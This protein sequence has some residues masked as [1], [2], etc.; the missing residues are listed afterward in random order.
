MLLRLLKW[1]QSWLR[2]RLWRSQSLSRKLFPQSL[3]KWLPLC[4]RSFLL[5]LHKWQQPFPELFPRVR[6]LWHKASPKFCLSNLRQ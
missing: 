2:L 6:W 4:R 1:P 5:K 3:R